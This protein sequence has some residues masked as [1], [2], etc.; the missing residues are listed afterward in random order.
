LPLDDYFYALQSIIPH[1]TP[2]SLHR[3]LQHH[4]ISRLPEVTSD[5]PIK[6]KIKH[7]LIGY[8]HIDIAQVQTA[9]GKL[10]LYLAN[11]WT[12]KFAFI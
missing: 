7:Y 8:F 12:S 11:D 5:K 10:Y 2:S 3:C 4:G 6:K 1:L 9:E